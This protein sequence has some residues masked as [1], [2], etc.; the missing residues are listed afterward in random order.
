[1]D[2]SSVSLDSVQRWV[3]VPVELRCGEMTAVSA[4]GELAASVLAELRS[5]TRQPGDPRFGP[6]PSSD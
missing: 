1:M 4:P 2:H 3:L 6:A 5:V